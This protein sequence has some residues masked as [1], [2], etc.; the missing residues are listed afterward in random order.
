MSDILRMVLR[1]RRVDRMKEWATSVESG[2][3]PYDEPTR[4][5]TSPLAY[6]GTLPINQTPWKP[7]APDK[8]R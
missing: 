1:E 3:L 2:P 5:L 6:K 7:P 4:E 8:E